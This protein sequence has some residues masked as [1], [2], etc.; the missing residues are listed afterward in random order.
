MN[1]IMNR[2]YYG[3]EWML[4]KLE[5][6]ILKDVDIISEFDFTA[7]KS[8]KSDQFSLNDVNVTIDNGIIE[9]CNFH[10]YTYTNT[11]PA[12]HENARYNNEITEEF[13]FSVHVESNAVQSIII[14]SRIKLQYAAPD[15]IFKLYVGDERLLI[16]NNWYDKIG[17][18]EMAFQRLTV[19]K[20][21]PFD[22]QFVNMV[23]KKLQVI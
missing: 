20:P 1:F 19:D 9:I 3:Q 23:V 17:F 16:S 18:E 10:N 11:E 22:L 6:A 8:I 4:S 15:V 5:A 12:F 13:K 21:N 7:F 14:D 2:S